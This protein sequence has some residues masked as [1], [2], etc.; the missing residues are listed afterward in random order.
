[1]IREILS[2]TTSWIGGCQFA[3]AIALFLITNW[4]GKHSFSF[5]YRQIDLFVRDDEAPAFNYI[6]RVFTPIIFLII[7]SAI[8][9][10]YGLD[11]FVVNYFM[12]SVYYIAFRIFI[13]GVQ[14][15]FTLINWPKQILYYASI[16]FLSYLVYDKI[17]SVK[18]NVLP[19]AAN[20]MNEMWVIIILF[21]YSII[22]KLDLPIS[23]AEKRRDKYLDTN[24]LNFKVLYGS[25]INKELDNDI[26]KA[27]S[28]A[29]IIHENFNRSTIVRWLEN[30]T[31]FITRKPHSLGVMQFP[32][33]KYINDEKSVILGVKKVHDTYLEFLK[34][35][36]LDDNV[37]YVD[38]STFYQPVI[39]KY[40]GGNAYREAVG[41]LTETILAKYYP[42]T[43]NSLVPPEVAA[44]INERSKSTATE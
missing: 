32:T 6:I 16:L 10:Q 37:Y 27:V 9:Y 28:Y 41:K 42:K 38:N 8:F 40:N 4:I 19:D 12:V 14:G 29:I 17:I 25:V 22:N 15:R 5:G 36:V 13:N 3:L 21:M 2:Q 20:M 31:F 44:K 34:S 39:S 1:M 26:L 43:T 30:I 7:S 33:E 23:S 18:A 35:F 11:R 24:F